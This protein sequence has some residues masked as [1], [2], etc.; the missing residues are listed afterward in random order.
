MK[1]LRG[2]HLHLE[3]SSGIAG[4][5]A[6]AALVDL[7]VPASVVTGAVKAMGVRGLRVAF[8]RRKRG[9]FVG[10]S[11]DVTWPGQRRKKAHEHDH[12][13]EHAHAHDHAALREHEHEHEHAADLPP[14]S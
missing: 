4:D 10:K 6:V 8:G 12:E 9:A 5:M 3:P 2:L 11:F 7:G 14:S 1:A 13:H